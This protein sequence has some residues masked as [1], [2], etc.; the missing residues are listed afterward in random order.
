ML[1][2]G[3]SI[4]AAYGIDKQAGWVALLSQRLSDQCPEVSVNNASI[5]G[6]TSAGGLKR[7]PGLLKS[8]DVAL[9]VI[10]LGGNDGLRGLTPR[11]LE[12]N[13]RQMIARGRKA[14]ARVVLLGMKIPPNY[15]AAYR[16]LFDDVFRHVA[17]DTGVGFVP[18]LLEGV[19]GHPDLMQSDGIHPDAKAQGRL[20]D[21]AWPVIAG[22]LKTE[23]PKL[24]TRP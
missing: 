7:L 6:E 3:D 20:L 11:Q 1:I 14:G 23:C 17:K 10:E 21:N 8:R 19:G 16:R 22:A 9:L 15:G 4:S 13:L 18:F 2:L 12:R 24:E 5:S